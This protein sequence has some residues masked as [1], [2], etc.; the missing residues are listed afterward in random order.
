MGIP[1]DSAWL[2][3]GIRI[4]LG[5]SITVNPKSLEVKVNLLSRADPTSD[6]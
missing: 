3:G 4:S 1:G 5:K 6:L 2:L